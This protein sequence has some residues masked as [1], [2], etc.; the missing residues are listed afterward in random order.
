MQNFP[1]KAFS[2]NFHGRVNELKTPCRI[3]TAFTPP[4]DSPPPFDQYREF[5]AVWDTGAQCTVISQNVVDQ[6]QLQ[7]VGMG[8][9]ID[10]NGN[11]QE[12][13]VY[14]TSLQLLNGVIV[15][16]IPTLQAAP[17]NCDVLIG[18][19]II[20][21][22]DLAISNYKGETVMS[23]RTPSQALID[24]VR[25]DSTR[26]VIPNKVG[27]NESCPCG[28]GKKYKNCHGK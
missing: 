15:T 18:M 20:T 16:Y 19:D 4:A 27:R 14:D 21:L 10:A 1:P 7:P 5:N 26:V 8:F 22:G 17:G 28:S 11:K 25:K 2:V 24:F 12:T 9:L 23:F 3:S 6:C 13:H